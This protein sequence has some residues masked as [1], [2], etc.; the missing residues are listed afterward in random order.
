MPHTQST[1]ALY[2]ELDVDYDDQQSAI[3][4][5]CRPHSPRLQSPP[6]AVNNRLTAVAVYIALDDGLR[7]EAKL[8]K[9]CRVWDKVPERS[10]LIFGD[11]L[12]F[13]KHRVA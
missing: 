11:T 1:I 5:D 6:S 8:S 7:T 3:V 9:S 10:T 2:T 12:I 13:L 4:V